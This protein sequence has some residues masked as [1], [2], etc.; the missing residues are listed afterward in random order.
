MSDGFVFQKSGYNFSL[1]GTALA[2]T[3]ASCNGLPVG[4]A[5]T[6]YAA[7]GDPTDAEASNGK[8]FATNSDGIIWA[9]TASMSEVMP[10]GGSPPMG[11]P[12][13]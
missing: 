10:E 11:A 9:H 13:Q 4:G 12:I 1:A 2:G 5:S 3:P 6:G 8:Y 7:V